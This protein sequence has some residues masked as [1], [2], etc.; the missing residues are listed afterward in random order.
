MDWTA[1]SI[2]AGLVLVVLLALKWA[3]FMLG[4]I[5][6]GLVAFGAAASLRM[7]PWQKWL[8]G[9]ELK[10]LAPQLPSIA[11]ASLGVG[12]LLL[13]GSFLLKKVTGLRVFMYILGAIAVAGI[14]YA[15]VAFGETLRVLLKYGIIR[16]GGDVGDL[17]YQGSR[18]QNL[19]FVYY[20]LKTEHDSESAFPKASK[21]MDALKD[22]VTTNRLSLQEAE[23]KFADPALGPYRQGRYGIA[24]NDAASRKYI[25]DIPKKDKTLLIFT[26]TD[27]ARNAH[28]DPKRLLPD[29]PRGGANLG[30]TA[31]GWLVEI[32]KDLSLKRLQNLNVSGP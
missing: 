8:E 6:I 3:Q 25:D 28:G 20:A 9:G 5:G 18:K 16:L 4:L 30:V 1:A 12:A 17:Q 10:G 11:Y 29:P 27:T 31:D 19:Q 21:W 15:G 13:V 23:K 26:A 2:L 22:R 14:G 7:E 32:G 24:F